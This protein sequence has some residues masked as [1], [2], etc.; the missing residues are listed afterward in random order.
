MNKRGKAWQLL[1]LGILIVAG[2]NPANAQQPADWSWLDN[3]IQSSMKDWKVP[4]VSVAV[5]RDASP[6]YVK[7]F[8]VRDI[9]SQSP[10]T[11][12]TLF[13]IGSCTK[14]FTSAAIAI[15][16]DQHK[17]QWDAKVNTYV[18][19]FHL[20]DP[21]ADEYVTIR[22]LLT[23]RTGVP[24]ADLMWYQSNL[25]TDQLIRRLAYVKPNAGFRTLFQYQNMMYVVAGEAVAH[26]SGATWGQFVRQNIFQPLAMTDSDTSATDAQKSSDYATPHQSNPDG[27]V[28]P[29]AWVNI[30]NVGPAGSINSGARDMARW[31]AFQLG[32]GTYQGKRLISAPNLEIM[33]TPQMVIPPGGEIPTVFFPDSTQLSYGLGW[34]VQQYRGHQLVL[35]AGDI[36]GFSA[37]V[38]LIP[39][40]HTGYFVAIN[41]SSS[42]RQVLSYEIADKLLGLP[43]YNW[44]AHFHKLEADLKAQEKAGEAWQSKR[45]PGTHPSRDLA[46]YAGKYRNPAYGEA[47]VVFQGAGLG[48]RFHSFSSA[49]E[50]WQYD[51]F[52]ANLDGKTRLTFC[53]DDDGKVSGFTMDGIRFDRQPAPDSKQ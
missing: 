22:D 23:H 36:D 25:P 44:S 52:V 42:Y 31:L 26:A 7:G 2:A 46:A 6:V 17:M 35:H 48:F 53:L 1:L 13:D 51:T 14:A 33:H 49:L 27:S 9:R 41:L 45:V 29:I 16:V 8:G 10:V 4:G 24:G 5:V 19:F 32:N 18:P 20:Q 38:V 15:L 39:D 50:H 34:F 11:P 37:M 12:D 28:K 30:D 3:F 21:L 47:Q 40:I 43:Q